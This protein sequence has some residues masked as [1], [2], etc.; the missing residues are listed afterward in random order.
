M[1]NQK[2]PLNSIGYS[3]THQVVV[4]LIQLD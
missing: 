3:Q 2:K 1:L 4:I